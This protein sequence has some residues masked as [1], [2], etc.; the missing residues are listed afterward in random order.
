MKTVEIT[1]NCGHK[2]VLRTPAPERGEPLWCL[3][4]NAE[5][6]VLLAPP[7][8]RARCLKKSCKYATKRA[9][10][11]IETV[12]ASARRH[13]RTYASHTVG[14]YDGADRIMEVT[15]VEEMLVT[16]SSMIMSRASEK[17]HSVSSATD[18]PLF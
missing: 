1:L 2:K 15:N 7:A 3:G 13:T 8:L 16:P 11:V 9:T 6:H 17:H 5:K 4:C 14:I 10:S 12:K 18:E